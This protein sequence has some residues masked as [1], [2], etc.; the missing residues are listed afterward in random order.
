VPVDVADE[1]VDV[2]LELGREPRLADP[3]DADDRD[4]ACL[5]LLA[6]SVEEVLDQAHLSF[7]PD[8][9]RLEAGGAALTPA[10]RDHA[11]CAPE[12]HRLGLAL[13]LVIARVLVGD[14]SVARSSRPLA[15]ENGSPVAA[16]TRCSVDEVAGDIPRLRHRA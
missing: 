3:G 12:R 15:D 1:P 9:G 11:G 13:Q 7:A 10:R 4:E 2:P 16:C 14:R 5:V 8:E 6:R